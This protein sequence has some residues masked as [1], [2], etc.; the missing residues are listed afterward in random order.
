MTHQNRNPM[1]HAEGFCPAQ[2][3]ALVQAAWGMVS[4]FSWGHIHAD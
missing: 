2:S 4:R 1:S 3:Y